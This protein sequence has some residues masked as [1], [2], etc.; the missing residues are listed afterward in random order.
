M[1]SS[2]I[3]L[4]AW[5]YLQRKHVYPIRNENNEIIASKLQIY[6]GD[7]EE[8][9]CFITPEAYNSLQEWMNYHAEHGEK[10]YPKIHG[11]CE[12]CVCRQQI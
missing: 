6:P 10:K 11:L 3:R 2:G 4:G 8:Y 5:D 7:L 9:F 12:I 1:A